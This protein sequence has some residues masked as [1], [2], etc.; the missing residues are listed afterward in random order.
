MHAVITGPLDRNISLELALSASGTAGPSDFDNSTLTY[1]F[2]SGS[3]SASLVCN[4]IVITTDGIVEDNEDFAFEL[5]ATPEFED[6]VITNGSG[7]IMIEDS[8]LDSM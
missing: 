6:V 7:V 5:V 8:P 4:A 3:A 2:P 1:T